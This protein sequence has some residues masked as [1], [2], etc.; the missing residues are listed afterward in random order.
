MNTHQFPVTEQSYTAV[1]HIDDRK[2][3]HTRPLQ[4]ND[5]SQVL[6]SYSKEIY[7][8]KR[9][10]PLKNNGSPIQHVHAR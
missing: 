10:F 1:H 8:V 4:K 5:R 3:S 2:I 9:L 7:H 6:L